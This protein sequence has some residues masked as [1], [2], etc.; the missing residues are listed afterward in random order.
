MHSKSVRIC[1]KRISAVS[2]IS[3]AKN[4]DIKY[5]RPDQRVPYLV[6]VG[7]KE[8]E[9][10]LISVRNRDGEEGKQ[11]LGQMTVEMLTE[12]ISRECTAS[13]EAS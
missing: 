12:R 2:W 5:G 3:E 6:I 9:T 8:E 11:D 7:E 4:W 10:K 13:G 1:E